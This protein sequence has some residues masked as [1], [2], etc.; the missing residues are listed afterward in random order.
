MVA[1]SI[2]KDIKVCI[3]GLVCKVIKPSKSWM[4]WFEPYKDVLVACLISLQIR[5]CLQPWMSAHPPRRASDETRTP[6]RQY[7]PTKKGATGSFF[8]FE[9]NSTPTAYLPP[10]QF[11]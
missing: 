10:R 4:I 6:H 5:P 1:F 9:K 3:E 11:Y 8:N 7:E 2:L